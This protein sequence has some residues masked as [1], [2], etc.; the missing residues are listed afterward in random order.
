MGYAASLAFR[1]LLFS[2]EI[3]NMKSIIC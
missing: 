2:T 3:K 1:I